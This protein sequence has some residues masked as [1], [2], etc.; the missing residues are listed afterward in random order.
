METSGEWHDELLAANW[1]SVVDKRGVVWV[2][3]DLCLQGARVTENALAWIKDRPGRKHLIS[4][5]HDNV[6]PGVERNF[7][8]WM[9]RY[10]EVFETVQPFVR[11]R[12]AAQSVLMSHFPYASQGDHTVTERYAQWRLPDMGEWLLHGHVHS[13]EKIRGKM[14]H[15]G[16]DAWNFTPVGQ[17]EIIELMNG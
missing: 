2:L 17:D 3:G 8:K 4:G 11:R 7:A 12:I 14:I 13:R 6:H 5:N 1:D 9:P 16:V 15:V 10:L